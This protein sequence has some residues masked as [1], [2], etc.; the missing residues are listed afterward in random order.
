MQAKNHEIDY[1][2]V[3]SG[4]GGATVAK[5]LTQ[6]KKKVLILEWGDNDPLTGSFWY[7]LKS[8]LWPGKCLLFTGQL[9]GLVRGVT[10][11]GST[12]FYY[13]TCFPVPIDMLNSHGIDITL[14]VDEMR[15]ELPVAPLKD[16]MMGPMAKR[17]MDSARELGYNWRKLDKFMYQDRW[18][19]EYPF[20]HFGDPHEVKWSS[21]M[22]I[23]EALKD[24]AKLVTGARVTRV[25]TENHAA[26]GVEYRK[27]GTIHKAFAPKTIVSAGGIGT[28]TI[29]RASGIKRA[30]Y[31]F[32][33]DPLIGVRGTVKD[34]TVPPSEIPMSAGVHM[35]DEGYMM[36][37]MVFPA[38]TTAL[39]TAQVFRFD[40]L[41][42]RRNTLQ[43][44]VKAKD[45]L[46]GKLTDSGGVRKNLDENEKKKL[47]RGYERAKEILKNA[48]AKNTYKTWYL[49]AHPGGTVKVGDLLDSDLK[50]EYDNLY[51]CD[52][53]VIP[54]AWGL[55]PTAT[56]I[57]LGK[58]LAKHL[59]TESTKQESP[60][61]APVKREEE[62]SPA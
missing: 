3:G 57:G 47:Q 13:A 11:G 19:P 12:V 22:Y 37:D 6:R 33:F 21:R 14:E 4:P 8:L 29:L 48:G 50:T 53:S 51:V 7:G 61:A 24:G 58:R 31:D 36:T 17:I 46:G 30:G 27:R 34:I 44:L 49:A 41:F 32:F 62:V 26:I 35:Q 16:E 18:R 43:I 23:E 52:C 42:S 55:P 9:L 40:K 20:G 15:A 45:A 60:A 10:T 25:I 38:A 2:V 28:P 54:E 5:E 59:S 39:F 56:I 1:I